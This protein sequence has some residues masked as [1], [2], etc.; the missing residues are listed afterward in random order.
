MLRPRPIH[1]LGCQ[2]CKFDDIGD[3]VYCADHSP[4]VECFQC[5]NGYIL[6]YQSDYDELIESG[7]T[8]CIPC[9]AANRIE[10]L[11]IEAVEGKK[12][13]EEEELEDVLDEYL[14]GEA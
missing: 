14:A 13:S 4:L 12:I 9:C 10:Q 1:P 6:E 8:T 11:E 2:D 5:G 3:L 7:D